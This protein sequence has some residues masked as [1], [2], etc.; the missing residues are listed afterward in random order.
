MGSAASGVDS[1]IQ[2]M[3]QNFL[4]AVLQESSTNDTTCKM[5]I[6]DKCAGNL[7][8]WQQ[9]THVCSC[10]VESHKRNLQEPR[11]VSCAGQL[12]HSGLCVKFV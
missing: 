4:I 7:R 10:S 9:F 12:P 2:I 1:A 3:Q 8:C 11:I 6:E 5:L